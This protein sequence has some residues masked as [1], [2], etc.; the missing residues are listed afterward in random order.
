M[1]GPGAL[2]EAQA[3]LN[4]HNDHMSIAYILRSACPDP[5]GSYSGLKGSG[6]FTQGE[7]REGRRLPQLMLGR[8][9]ECHRDRLSRAYL[10]P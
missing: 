1:A 3:T 4:P 6:E 2:D 9:Q 8:I 5:Q 10:L 7:V